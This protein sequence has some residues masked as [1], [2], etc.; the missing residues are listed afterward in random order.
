M[1]NEANSDFDDFVSRSPSV[2][3]KM[4]FLYFFVPQKE[5][6]M[7]IA[8]IKPSMRSPFFWG[9]FSTVKVSRSLKNSRSILDKDLAVVTF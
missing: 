6:S 4:R 8:T 9:S 3:I 1:I 7:S 2:I 5:F